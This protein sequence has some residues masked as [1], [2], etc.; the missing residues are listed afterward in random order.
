MTR[1]KM[2]SKRHEKFYDKLVNAGYV[3]KIH[4]IDTQCYE[5]VEIYSKKFNN[6][7]GEFSTLQ[8]AWTYLHGKEIV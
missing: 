1:A 6:F 4:W 2:W 7:L 8:V 3:V 5:C